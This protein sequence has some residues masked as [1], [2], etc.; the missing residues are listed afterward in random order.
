MIFVRPGSFFGFLTGF[1]L[2]VEDCSWTSTR[3]GGVGLPG[4]MGGWGSYGGKA[5]GVSTGTRWGRYSS[6]SPSCMSTSPLSAMLIICGPPGPPSGGGFLDD[7]AAT[8]SG[9]RPRIGLGYGI[10]IGGA[11][12]G[13]RGGSPDD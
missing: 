11:G 1:V 7:G 9:D 4:I 2:L 3:W 5:V 6:L 13:P 8:G 12:E 10:D